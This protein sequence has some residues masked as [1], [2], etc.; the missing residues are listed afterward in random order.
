[1]KICVTEIVVLGST[2]QIGGA[3]SILPGRADKIRDFLVPRNTTNIRRFL[4]TVAMTRRWC[5]NYGEISRPLSRLT[6]DIPFNWGDAEAASFSILRDKCSRIVDAHGHDPKYGCYMHTDASGYAI[7]CYITQMQYQDGKD[8]GRKI[9]VPI[10]YDSVLLKAPE[11]NYGTYKRELLAIITFARKYT[12]MFL[13]EEQSVF[14]TDHKPLTL[15]MDS[16]NVQGIYARWQSELNHM[17]VRIEYIEGVRN[18]EADAL[19]RTIFPDQA[20]ENDEILKSLGEIVRDSDGNPEWVWKDGKGGYEELLRLRKEEELK[21]AKSTQPAAIQNSNANSTVS[22]VRVALEADAFTLQLNELWQNHDSQ[23]YSLTWSD[24]EWF[25]A[26]YNFIRYAIYPKGYDRLQKVALQRRAAHYSLIGGD[27]LIKQGGVLRRCVPKYKV[28]EMLRAAHDLEGH[29]QLGL[30]LKKLKAYYWPNMIKDVADYIAG[31][32]VCAKHGIAQR[33]QT[34]SPIIVNEPNIL[35]G[36]DFVGP[37]PRTQVSVEELVKLCFPQITKLK[38]DNFTMK[39]KSQFT[40]SQANDQGFLVFTHI[41][42]VV[43][44]FSRFIWAFPCTTDDCEEVIR[45]LSWLFPCVGTPVGIYTDEGVHFAGQATRDFLG[46]NG[47]MWIP[48]PVGAKKATGMVEMCNNL[49]SKVIKKDEDVP[50]NWPFKV[51]HAA[52]ETNRR[53][54]DYCSFSPFEIRCGYQPPSETETIIPSY[55]RTEWQAN[56]NKA[57]V[58]TA[59]DFDN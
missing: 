52:F 59:L 33:S 36:M 7:G 55:T 31:C 15:F 39:V 1:M 50:E 51:Q 29:W 26:Y 23:P 28:A 22:L 14:F 54:I 58:F 25:S 19:S 34:Q 47:V 46:T 45:C 41:L 48:S 3:I 13:A 6:G 27:L 57:E 8:S 32:I 18:K 17:N 11:R 37:L 35:W 21:L 4:G 49:L 9:E 20:D 12:H 38:D 53:I 40:G 56:I 43:D 2:H 24:D 30:T 10:L 16:H 5:K 44:Y 42:V